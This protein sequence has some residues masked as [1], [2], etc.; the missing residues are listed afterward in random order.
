VLHARHDSGAPVIRFQ[1][2]ET[3]RWDCRVTERPGWTVV[4]DAAPALPGEGDPVYA[5]GRPPRA[6]Q[7]CYLWEQVRAPDGGVIGALGEDVC[8]HG[9][10]AP[11]RS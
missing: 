6:G 1:F 3:G 7:G 2:G 10:P 11:A 5:P 9:A 8:A 4:A